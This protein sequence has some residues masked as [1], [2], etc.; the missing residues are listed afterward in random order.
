Q[1]TEQVFERQVIN[2]LRLVNDAFLPGPRPAIEQAIARGSG[3]TVELIE[4][5]RRL[6]MLALRMLN[7]MHEAVTQR[8]L[9]QGELGDGNVELSKRC[10]A[11]SLIP[12]PAA[13]ALLLLD[14]A[15]CVAFLQV[16]AIESQCG[17]HRN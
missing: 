5:C 14:F 6:R 3:K 8:V 15:T 2:V 13:T 9:L 1:A 7:V 12:N 11:R 10:H 16:L 17:T 4:F